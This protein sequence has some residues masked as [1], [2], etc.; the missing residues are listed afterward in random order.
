MKKA[1]NKRFWLGILVIVLAAFLTLAAC[2][3]AGEESMPGTQ[4]TSGKPGDNKGNGGGGAQNTPSDNSGSGTPNTPAGGNGNGGG[5]DTSGT[6]NTVAVTGVSLKTSTSLVVGSTEILIAT[7]TPSNATNQNVTWG[8]SNTSVATVTEGG[9]VIAVAAGNA[10]IT[11]TTDDGK[12][13]AVCAVTVRPIVVSGVTLKESTYLV[14]GNTET[15]FAIIEPDNATNQNV[16][17]NSSNPAAATVSTGGEVTAVAAGTA[18]ITVTTVDG[19][20]QAACSVT[21]SNYAVSVTG[22]S[23]NKSSAGLVVSETEDLTATITPYNATNQK[24]V[25]NSSNT[26]VATV[27]AG[28][29]VTAKNIGTTTITVTTDD[30]SKTASCSITVNPKAITF[31]VDTIHAQTYTGSAIQPVVTVM[32][33]TTKLA[34]NTD[35]TVAYT[36]NINAGTGTVTISGVGNYAGSSG[37]RT[38]PINPKVITFTVDTIPAQ[39]YTGSAFQPVVTVRD[40]STALTLTTDYTVTYTNNT[41]AGTAAVTISGA[42]NYAGSSGSRTFTINKAAGTTVSAPTGSSY[43]SGSNITI[44]A[45]TAPGNGQTVEY[46]RNTTNAAPSSGW[47][48]STIFGW[49]AG[50]NYFFARSKENINYNAG[51]PSAGLQVITQKAAG[52]AVTIPTVNLSPTS[53]SITVNEVNLVTA[54]GQTVE[55]AISTA[56][57]VTGSAWQASTTFNNLNANTVYYVYARSAGNNNYETGTT[58]ISGEIMTPLATLW[59]KTITAGGKWA[60]FYAVAVDSSGNVYAAGIQDG[61]GNYNSRDPVLVKYDSSGTTQWAKT[62]TAGN[63]DAEF[64]AVAVDSSGNVY[65][66]GSQG[67]TGNYNYGS[68][69]IAGVCSSFSSSIYGNPVLVKYNSFGTSQWAKTITAGNYM[70]GF[71]A[72]AVDSGGNIYALGEQYGTGNY[73]YGSGNIAGTNS[74]DNP[75]LVKYGK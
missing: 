16:T 48:D 25:W 60:M 33:G 50:T 32:D 29:V 28:G 14:V 66:A 69:N 3:S 49:S 30:G 42:G 13:K 23:L 26:T 54:T 20:H 55:Y 64:Y 4:T 47:Q 52:A 9:M 27:S 10:T 36:N 46:A 67:G 44:N 15:L 57:N 18:T 5:N 43:V 53:N 70:A 2:G 35:Y 40:G 31:T 39:T 12:Y 73:N 61:T 75:V 6:V 17:W 37:S 41:N 72:V 58:S 71:R 63:F 74:T 65:A 34:L 11:V 62:V 51:I 8:S 68:G 45:V 22:V 7:I 59:A 21:V 1:V 19:G 56:N 24:I 38:F